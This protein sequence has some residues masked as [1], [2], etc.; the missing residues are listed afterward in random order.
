[1][2]LEIS[3]RNFALIDNVRLALAPGL[4]VL[5]G[6][7]GAGKSII[8]DAVELA[9]G[10][11][12][13]I[14]IIR[15]GAEKAVVDVVFDI[16][17]TPALGRLVADMGLGEATDPTLV[18][19]REVPI[20]GRAT[21]RAN[22]RTVNLSVLRELTE[23]LIDIHGQHEH[24]SLLRLDRHVDLLDAFGGDEAS[25]LRATVA[26]AHRAWQDTLEEI[27]SLAGDERDRA[28]RVDL[29]KFQADEIRRAQ[30][31]PHEEEALQEERRLL[32]SAEKRHEATA[33]AYACLYGSEGAGPGSAH[34]QL[35]RALSSL[36]DMAAMD[37]TA[38][39]ML[40][41]VRQASYQIDD[42]ARDIRQ[43][44]DAIF[45]DPARLAE[46]ESRLDLI[47]SLKR[48]YGADLGEVLSF[49]AAAA[50]ELERLENSAELLAALEI[51]AGAERDQLE[52]LAAQ[53]TQTRHRVADTLVGAIEGSLGDLGMK[54]TR[55]GV[56]LLP[57]TSPGPRGAERVEF[58]FSPNPGEPPKPLGRIAS[59]GE[60]SRVM[61][62]LKAILA[63]T[64]EI[65]TMI[66]DEI[67]SGVGGGA[68]Q[69]VGEKLAA[70]ALTRQVVCVTHLARIA[71]LANAHHLIVKES[72]G[73]RTETR[74]K[75]LSAGERVEE[76]ARMLAGHPPTPITLA[77]AQEMLEQGE[78]TVRTLRAARRVV[79]AAPA[80]S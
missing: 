67:D 68:A 31:K 61:L 13:S 59:G 45:F 24:Q 6:E 73:Q 8:I 75:T 26:A 76:V 56:S 23:R 47:G 21:C 33:R 43:Y 77:N 1:V 25:A 29:L 37:P 20:D 32:A 51:R 55:F 15:T 3:I 57:E 62:A 40:E 44:R 7:T 30:L 42:T 5:T 18:I 70:I 65:S 66:F 72:T 35:G 2:L 14:D 12:A 50:G 71:S 48:K 22:G 36:E 78:S 11:R 54:K 41:A 49:A 60:M 46:V 74:V 38:V 34:D 53:L 10:A 69:A 27:R 19:S 16:M 17:E 39:P 52:A 64:D 58:L 4:N 63:E 80:D 9:L 79:T 28:R